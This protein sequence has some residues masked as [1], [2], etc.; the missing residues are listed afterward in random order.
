MDPTRI[1]AYEDVEF[2]RRKYLQDKLLIPR[3]L[4]AFPNSAGELLKNAK[5]LQAVYAKAAKSRKLPERLPESTYSNIETRIRLYLKFWS[6]LRRT[7]DPE[8]GEQAKRRLRKAFEALYYPSDRREKLNILNLWD[9]Y[10]LERMMVENVVKLLRRLATKHGVIPRRDKQ[11]VAG[12]WGL[13]LAEVEKIWQQ[14][15]KW[16]S[17]AR[18]RLVE[19]YN[20]SNGRLYRLIPISKK[21]NVAQVRRTAKPIRTKS[22]GEPL[23]P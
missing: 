3:D 13:T 14:R 21:G 2:F 20:V 6:H 17:Y 19:R 22:F 12:G 15:K 18:D 9:E 5:R 8:F 23:R 7:K 10:V 4:L 11:M 1:D 16:R